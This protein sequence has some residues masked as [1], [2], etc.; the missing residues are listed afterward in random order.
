MPLESSSCR[1]QA[2]TEPLEQP[3]KPTTPSELSPAIRAFLKSLGARKARYLK[4]AEASSDYK[5]GY[6]L[7]NCDAEIQARGGKIVFGWVVWELP[8]AL[9]EGEFHAG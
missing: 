4:Y 5:A 9:I 1:Q 7:N 2:K 6:C 8:G 3:M